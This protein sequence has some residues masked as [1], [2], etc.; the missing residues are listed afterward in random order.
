MILVVGGVA[1][2]KLEFA[3]RELGVTTW[4]DGTLGSENCVYRLQQV[5]RESVDP[6]RNIEKWCRV[7]PQGVLICDE[8]GCGVTP[9]DGEER[10]WREQVGRVCC[11]LAESCEAVYRVC[12]GLG[13]RIK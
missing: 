11:R 1:Q 8:V 13:R 4:N 10:L 3:Q 6:W 5:V 2:G 7:H 9:M 12:C